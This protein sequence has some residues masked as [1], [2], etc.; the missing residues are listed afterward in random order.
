VKYFF[1]FFLLIFIGLN[2]CLLSGGQQSEGT[3]SVGHLRCEYR[4]NPMGVDR[5]NPLL[6]WWLISAQ[7]GQK[8]EAYQII[9]AS[10]PALLSQDKGDLWDSG[11]VSSDNTIQIPYQGKSLATAQQVFWKVRSWDKSGSPTAWSDV[12]SWTMGP[13]SEKDWEGAQ[14]ISGPIRSEWNFPKPVKP[15]PTPLPGSSP[16]QTPISTPTPS[17]TPVLDAKLTDSI[18]LKRDFT[19]SRKVKRATLFVCGLGQYEMFLN[20]KPVTDT[21]LNPGWSQYRKTCLYNSY[22]VTGLIGS[23]MNRIAA[24]LGNSFFNMHPVPPGR[25]Q[26]NEFKPRFEAPRL[27]ARLLLEYDDGSTDNVVSNASWLAA[28]GPITLSHIYAGEDYDAR[29]LPEGWAQAGFNASSWSPA[30]IVSG[31][32]GI[33]KG[34]SASAPPIR[35]FETMKP[36]GSKENRPGV[37]TYDFGQN[38]AVDLRMKVKGPA[39][40]VV[41]VEPS[42]LV[43]AN[44]L[45]AQRG[46]G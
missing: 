38:A 22:D 26:K 18:L 27:I 33:L 45:H 44:G 37:T 42:E 34:N 5:T 28:P 16:T 8:Q 3:V 20:G 19:T 9:V 7:R 15:T 39:G 29:L 14:W 17:P 2:T 12:A 11:K 40:S 36:F 31:P 6:S 30:G 25:Y 13:M 32:G 46:R 35:F 24:I 10:D 21:F 1:P 43:D 23:G 41:R 4:E